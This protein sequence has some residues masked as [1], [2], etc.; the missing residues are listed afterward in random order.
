MDF[1]PRIGLTTR[2]EQ[3]TNRFYLGR[4]YS[5][6]VNAFGGLPIHI[7]LIPNREYV[8]SIVKDLDGIL[9]PGSNTD[10]DPLRFGE[11]PIP[12]FRVNVPEKDETDLLVL[13]A[14]FESR[15]PVLGICF[16]MQVLNVFCGGTL[17][18]DIETQVKNPIKH[19]Q[20]EPETRNSHRIDIEPGSIISN[21][22][23]SDVLVNSLHHQ[24][25][26]EPGKG[27]RVTA[28][29]SDGVI[30]CIEGKDTDHFVLGVQWH[31]EQTWQHDNT[32]K[33]I[34]ETF[35]RKCEERRLKRI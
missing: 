18:Q 8:S 28:R 4:H 35:V 17:L 1:A 12:G 22:A 7:P 33:S 16:G 30:E 27:L 6:V 19:S 5:E 15:L 11:E 24:A 10:V 14:A 29:A 9:L 23:V 26:R 21:F 31:P 32:S 2:L 13:E 3:H 34:F 25:V 20:G